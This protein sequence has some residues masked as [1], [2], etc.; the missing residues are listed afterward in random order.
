MY[1]G[2]QL[3][4]AL[5]LVVLIT[6]VHGF[7]VVMMTKLLRLEDSTLRAHRLD[8]RAFGL[9]ILMALCLFALHALEICIFGFFY[10]AA[11]AIQSLEEALYSPLRATRPWAIRTSPFPPSGGCWAR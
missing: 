2:T 4:V 9:L 1:L 10:L 5:F 3:L 7:G 8:Y 11:G 6:L